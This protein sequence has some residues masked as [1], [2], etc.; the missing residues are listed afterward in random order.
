MLLSFMEKTNTEEKS[1][2]FSDLSFFTKL[3]LGVLALAGIVMI[4]I[5]VIQIFFVDNGLTKIEKVLYM[6]GIGSTS[7]ETM[8]KMM[9]SQNVISGFEKLQQ[10]ARSFTETEMYKKFS[11]SL[12]LISPPVPGKS[13]SGLGN[14]FD[15]VLF[16]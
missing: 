3:F 13:G 7:G 4:I 1:C 5:L 11:S 15:H 6:L 2:E 8:V 10:A 14:I 9:N 12:H 16:S